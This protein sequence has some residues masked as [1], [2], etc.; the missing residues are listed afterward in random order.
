MVKGKRI[1]AHIQWGH[2]LMAL[3]AVLYLVWLVVV[4][5]AVFTLSLICYVLYYRLDALP[6]FIDGALPLVAVGL[7]SV[8][9]PLML[10]L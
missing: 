4:V 9:L 6:S 5:V 10:K 7:F 3:C 8:V 2:W 1:L